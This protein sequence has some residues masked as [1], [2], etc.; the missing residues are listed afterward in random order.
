MLGD[1]ACVVSRDY[2]MSCEQENNWS[3][4]NYKT[5]N[6]D[7]QREKRQR[8]K[9]EDEE[10]ITK[11]SFN[12]S[13]HEDLASGDV[14]MDPVEAAVDPHAEDSS[15]SSSLIH[16]IGRDN[17]ISCL[18][19]SSRSDYGAIA[20]LNQSFRKLIRSGEVYKLR[21]QYGMVEHWVYFSCQLLEWEAFD[22]SRRRW[23]HL[24]TMDPNECFLSSDKESLAV[25]AELLVFGKEVMSNV[26]YQYSLLTNSW[27]SGMRMNASRCLFGSASLGEIAILAGG[28][29][30]QG[31]TLSSAELYDSE[32]G[33]W[34]TLPSMNK[35][36]KMCSAI[37]W[38]TNI[39]SLAVLE[40]GSQSFLHVGKNMIWKL[41]LGLKFRACL[42]S[43]LVQLWKPELLLLLKLLLWLQL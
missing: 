5:D 22:P 18:I 15:D 24:P 26:I 41:K 29:N 38:I 17:T 13:D 7:A 28:C 6:N 14:P 25:G 4:T 33:S 35:P 36:R 42:L 2:T 23:M 20:S 19:R 39:M 31:N 11:K 43:D 10:V 16:D 34:S 21:R 27:S 3:S 9:N 32:R 30:S 12:Q 8:E 37:L 40:E 1:R